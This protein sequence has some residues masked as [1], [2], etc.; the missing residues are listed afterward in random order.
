MAEEAGDL[1]IEMV[2]LDDGWFGRGTMICG[3]WE[4]GRRMKRSWDAPWEN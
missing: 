1:G 2:V 3:G 4:T